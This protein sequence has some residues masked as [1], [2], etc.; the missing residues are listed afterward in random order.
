MCC[1]LKFIFPKINLYYSF[2]LGELLARDNTCETQSRVFTVDK[3]MPDMARELFHPRPVC[4]MSDHIGRCEVKDD[5]QVVIVPSL[6]EN[7]VVDER[8]DVCGVGCLH[9]HITLG[10]FLGVENILGKNYTTIRQGDIF[11]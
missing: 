10:G 8:V 3:N 11:A 6:P 5:L 7:L 4:W 9:N 1:L 2:I